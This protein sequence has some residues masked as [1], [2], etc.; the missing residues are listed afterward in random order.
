MDDLY[1]P[2]PAT[3]DYPS[4][5]EAEIALVP[6]HLDFPS[7]LARQITETAALVAHFGETGA[8]IRY[9]RGKWSVRET[10]GHLSDCER[11]LSY[12]ML[13]LI[14][15][16]A[17]PLPGFDH[18]AYVPAADFEARTLL[19]VLEEFRAVRAATIALVASTRLEAF[20]TRGQVG[21]SF[22]TAAALAY[23]IAGHERHH[24]GLLETKYLPLVSPAVPNLG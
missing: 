7:M 16:D 2:R 13:R 4:A 10:V 11:I 8:S 19:Q 14:R 6:Q 5:F 17:P 24:R 21:S 18:N 9:A 12:R 15:G 20:Q 3:D 22:I 23:L 1:L